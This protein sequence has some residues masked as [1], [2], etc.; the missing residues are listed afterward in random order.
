MLEYRLVHGRFELDP[1][2]MPG[3]P[4]DLGLDP[5]Q[6]VE[7]HPDALAERGPLDKFDLAPLGREVEQADTEARAAAPADSDLDA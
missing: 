1:A 2:D 5:L 4:P 3:N 6:A 7:L